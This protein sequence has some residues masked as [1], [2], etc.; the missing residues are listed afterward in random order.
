MT[1][2]LPAEAQPEGKHFIWAGQQYIVN[3]E[4]NTVHMAK[5]VEHTGQFGEKALKAVWHLTGGSAIQFV[6]DH[7]Q[8]HKEVSIAEQGIQTDEAHAPLTEQETREA[9]KAAQKTKRSAEINE[10]HIQTPVVKDL[11][12]PVVPADSR[13]TAHSNLSSAKS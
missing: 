12:K 13:P 3:L 11:T 9:I 10:A 1:E 2:T 6:K 4:H 5:L 7:A 8:A